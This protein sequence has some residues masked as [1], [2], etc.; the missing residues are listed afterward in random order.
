[1]TTYDVY[2][3]GNALVDTEYEVD[4]AF[5]AEAKLPKGVMTLI[6]APD[7]VRLIQL[8]E[9]EHGREVIK[10]AGG[11]S[12]AN[13]MVAIAQLGGKAF[14]S[15]KVANDETGDFFMSDL[16]EAGVHTN[17][18]ETREAGIT[19]KCISM[20]TADAERTM[21]THLGI[22]QDLSVRELN[23]DALANSKYLYIEGYL[24]T[25]PAALEAAKKAQDIAHSSGCLVSVTLSDPAMVENFPGAFDDLVDGGIDLIF[26][27]QDEA[28]LWT[29]TKSRDEAM[30]ELK[31]RC[32]YIAMTCSQDGAM[33]HDGATTAMVAG[34]ATKAVD[35]TGAGDMFAGAF[36]YAINAGQTFAEAASF[37]NRAASLL[38]SSFGA[39][40]PMDVIRSR[41]LAG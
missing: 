23:A 4:D 12:A 39:R 41:L 15:C 21:T 5:L 38:V 11:G 3:I 36:L 9:Q 26:C 8:L 33:V 1:M 7:R 24:V 40:L 37:A 35:T 13:T 30:A 6:E 32:R 17:L 2:G 16:N 22:T 25:S 10:Q 29:G 34:V 31:T 27:N 14:Y 20:I 18:N 28:M 19:G